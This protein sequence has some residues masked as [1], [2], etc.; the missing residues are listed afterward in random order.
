[1][2][3]RQIFLTDKYTY[4]LIKPHVIYRNPAYFNNH[5]FKLIVYKEHER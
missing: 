1:M 4:I 2:A 5:S 3:Q